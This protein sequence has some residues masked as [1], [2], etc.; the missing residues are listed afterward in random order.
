MDQNEKKPQGFRCTRVA[1]ID[2][3][4]QMICGYSSMEV[5]NSILTCEFIFNP[6]IIQYSLWKQL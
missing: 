1:L 5:K 2:G 6:K 4:S 3:C